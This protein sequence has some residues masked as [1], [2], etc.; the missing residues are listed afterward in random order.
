MNELIQNG[1][2][3]N[4][5]RTYTAAQKQYLQF[6]DEYK[7]CSV[8]TSEN[9]VLRYIAYMSTKPARKGKQ[10]LTIST[11]NV[12]LAA[13]RSLQIMAGFDAPIIHTPRVQLALKAISE[14]CD[15]PSQKMPITY[16]ILSWI[17]IPM[18][19]DY[20]SLVWKAV[21]TLGFFACLRGSEYTMVLDYKQPSKVISPPPLVNYVQFTQ[22]EGYPAMIYTVPKSK[23]FTHG[24]VKKCGL[25]KN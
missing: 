18:S 25:F 3:A 1:L 5:Q 13:V 2:R 11:M 21:L 16:D 23:T 9:T 15:P 8:P 20:N 7:L 14:S 10:G 19:D 24:F 12:Y 6:C 17:V 4:T 22:H